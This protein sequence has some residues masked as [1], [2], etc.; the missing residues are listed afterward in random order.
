MVLSSLVV[1]ISTQVCTCGCSC[2]RHGWEFQDWNRLTLRRSIVLED[3]QSRKISPQRCKWLAMIRHVE[4]HANPKCMP[5]LFLCM[6]YTDWHY[7][8][9]LICPWEWPQVDA[10]FWSDN[11]W[12]TFANSYFHII[13]CILVTLGIRRW[14]SGRSQ[15][16]TSHTC[17]LLVMTES[18]FLLSRGAQS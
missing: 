8:S 14:Q 17:Q 11:T 13:C 4:D 6:K 10:M 2:C 9:D 7:R 5:D 1:K 3:V 16:M 18:C 12:L 15:L